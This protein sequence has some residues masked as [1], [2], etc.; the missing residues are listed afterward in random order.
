MHP[1]ARLTENQKE[2]L[3]KWMGDTRDLIK[4]KNE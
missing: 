4:V 2:A 1:D 3:I